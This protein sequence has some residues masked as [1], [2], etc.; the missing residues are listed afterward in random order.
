MNAQNSYPF[1]READG[2]LRLTRHADVMRALLEHDLFSS[3]VSA[4][5]P[6]IP[7]GMDPPEHTAFRALTDRYFTRE[8]VDAFEP[9]CR[10]TVRRLL[11]QRRDPRFAHRLAVRLLCDF[12]GWKEDMDEALSTWFFAHEAAVA[13]GDRE[14]LLENAAVLAE[15]VGRELGAR[16]TRGDGS[17]ADLT[18]RLLHDRVEGRP[19]TDAEI[20]SILRNWTAGEVG[21]MAKSFETVLEFLEAEPAWQDWL[22]KHPERTNAFTDELLRLRA[23][24]PDNRRVTA[25]PVT[26]AGEDLPAG[27]KLLIDWAAANRDPAAFEDAERF[28]PDRDARNNLLYGAGIHAC[29]GATLARMELRVLIEERLRETPA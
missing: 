23:P 1:Q 12:L 22:R 20:V 29:P 10:E 25:C 18:A 6:A 8:I 19:L 15:L 3:S 27:Q 5:H 9:R 16:R 13:A 11:P 21:T 17:D 4:K 2:S 24:L 28:D 7:N 26:L 14:G